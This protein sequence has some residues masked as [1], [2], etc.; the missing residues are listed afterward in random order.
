MW[1]NIWRVGKTESVHSVEVDIFHQGIGV[2]SDNNLHLWHYLVSM[3]E[4]DLEGRPSSHPARHTYI[5]VQTPSW[6]STPRLLGPYLT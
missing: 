2:S 5:Y 6:K 3:M 4:T 1:S